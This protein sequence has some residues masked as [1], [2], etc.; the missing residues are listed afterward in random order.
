MMMIDKG[1]KRNLRTITT[2]FG[3]KARKFYLKIKYLKFI[4]LTGI[5]ILAFFEKP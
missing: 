3:I 5:V 2:P 1:I 4:T